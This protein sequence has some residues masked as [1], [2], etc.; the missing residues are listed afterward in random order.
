[1]FSNTLGGDTEVENLDQM[2]PNSDEGNQ[3]ECSIKLSNVKQVCI[4]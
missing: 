2:D 3:P 4:A 1:M